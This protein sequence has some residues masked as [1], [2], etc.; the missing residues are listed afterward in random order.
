[1]W[2]ASTR[3]DDSILNYIHKCLDTTK[4]TCF[5]DIQGHQ[6]QSGGT[7]PPDILVTTL[8]PD[9]VILDRKSNTLEIFELTVPGESRISIAHNIK[10]GKQAGAELGQAQLKLGLVS[11]NIINK[12]YIAGSLV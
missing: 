10:L 12:K 3:E 6:T 8:K 4:Y 1:M 2:S 11:T 9:I 5:T 7:I